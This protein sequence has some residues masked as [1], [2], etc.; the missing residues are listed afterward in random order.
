MIAA[1][2]LGIALAS[3]AGAAAPVHPDVRAFGD[4]AFVG[5]TSEV[6]LNQ[7]IVGIAGTKSAHGY[8]EAATDA[9]PSCATSI[10]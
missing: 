10:A 4:A 3:P 5:S 9:P 7:P 6:T 8:W 1:V 2:S